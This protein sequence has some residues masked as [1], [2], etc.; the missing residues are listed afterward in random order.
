MHVRR[1]CIGIPSF[2]PKNILENIQEVDEGFCY[3]GI[4]KMVIFGMT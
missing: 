4:D 2:V 3:N 1:A